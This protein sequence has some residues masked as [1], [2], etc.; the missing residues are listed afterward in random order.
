[1]PASSL[2]ELWIFLISPDLLHEEKT[3]A[4]DSY[5]ADEGYASQKGRH[6]GPVTTAVIVGIC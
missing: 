4:H 3:Q 1:M 6:V 2:I 5:E